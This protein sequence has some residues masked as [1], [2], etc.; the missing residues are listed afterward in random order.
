ML[1]LEREAELAVLDSAWESARDGGG[2]LVVVEGAAGNGKSALLAASAEH[3][4]S[5]GLLMRRA[6]G[7]ELERGLA[8]GAVRQLFEPVV[9]RLTPAECDDL[10]AG[11]AALAARVVAP[12]GTLD[13]QGPAADGGYAVLHGIYW[14]ATN[15]AQ[16]APMA[17]LVDDL[18]WADP[19]SVRALA[20]LAHRI[21]DLP[22][23][24]V[25]ALRPDEPGS[26]VELLDELRADPDAE[27][28]TVAPLRHRSVD[29]IVRSA[30]PD[31]DETL[32]AA[33]F[34]A[35]AGNPFYLRELLFTI[36]AEQRRGDSPPVV[37]E[38]SVPTLGDRVIRRLA[39]IGSEAV[40]LAQAMGVLGEGARLADAAALAGLD[41]SAAAAAASA[42]QRIEVLAGDDPVAF[43]HPLV[44][45]SLYDTLSVVERDAAHRTAALRLQGTG[46]SAEGIAAHLAAVR[47]AADPGVAR[48]LREA[49]DVATRRGAPEAASRWLDRA[50]AENAAEPPRA[51]LLHELGRVELACRDPA[52]IV[53]L[54][55]A[56]ELVAE[57]VTRGRIALDLAEILAAAGRWESVLTVLSDALVRL[58]D[59]SAEV[60]VEL[61]TFRAVI[62]AFD[63][64][65]VG[66]F[67]AD[68]DRLLRL[69]ARPGWSARALAALI[70]N[71]SVMRGES[72]SEARAL[73]DR[74]LRDGL[75]FSG[76][77]AG[78]WAHTPAL[79]AL[80]LLDA[81]DRALQVIDEL[82]SRALRDG[83]LIGTLTAM[84]YRG[85][86]SVRRGDLA[87]GEAEMRT[88]MEVSI[89][90]GMSLLVAIGVNFLADAMLE[91]PSL[92]D[93]AAMVEQLPLAPDFVATASGGFVL[94]ARGRLRVQRGEHESGL[95]DLR[96]C[97]Q[98]FAAL[99][100]GPPF[101]FWRSALALA[102]P[103]D[104]RDEA[105]SLMAE[106]L[107]L[108]TATGM[109]R[110]YG[111]ALRAAGLLVGGERGLGHLRESVTR[112]EGS[113]ARLEHARALVDYGAA[114][115]RSAQRAK[116][117]EPLAAGLELA[118]RCGAERLVARALEEI[119]A[120]GA[121]PRRIVRTGR[122]ALTASELRTARLVAQGR[123]NAEVAQ[124][125][126][127]SLKTVETHLSHAYAK[128]GL[129]GPGARRRLGHML[130]DQPSA[131]GGENLRVLP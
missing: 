128:L 94:E 31:A 35:T 64:R 75:L 85:W 71:V 49:A 17:L 81:D 126:F 22:I 98:V 40:A 48:A 108:A 56:L 38:V 26:P 45:R 50:V 66:S 111:I 125:L 4:A 61:E 78:G 36:A 5:C 62:R 115:R 121:R 1:L 25:V 29:T 12:D 110:P 51:V 122:A 123:S 99:G 69:T 57:S 9:A 2:R 74:G 39:R 73:L 41:E 72:L 82:A 63:P 83:E 21:S 24:M 52:A 106:E 131:A 95:A 28:I 55:E 79:T 44:R 97:G 27:R 86:I 119:R 88:C 14:L 77:G 116:A 32:S 10:F 43:V 76:H 46:A 91:R 112:L 37:G 101:S 96:A 54:H 90:N 107:A 13:R 47:P 53:H 20:Y 124:A 109:T 100:F 7:N 60:T 104:E 58:G 93:F 11:A 8:F 23:A 130:R 103:A 34:S 89:Q 67:D 84:G 114:L 19:S 117:R 33:C 87:T 15:L 68:R 105:L 16:L 3:A 102:L 70:A 113:A 59:S 92:D 129:A 127:V 42:M 65:L 30:I 6:R 18:H 120:A 80:V 118:Q